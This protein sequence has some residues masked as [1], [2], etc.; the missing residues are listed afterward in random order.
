MFHVVDIDLKP[1][2][3][4]MG[5]HELRV[6]FRDYSAQES[7]VGHLRVRFEKLIELTIESEPEGVSLSIAIGSHRRRLDWH[8]VRQLF[9]GLVLPPPE[10]ADEDEQRL[11]G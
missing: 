7:L 6:A 10:L 2:H 1:K 9:E 3:E 11:A 8:E 5:A 4:R